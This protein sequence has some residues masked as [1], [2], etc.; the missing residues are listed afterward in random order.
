M[1]E[2]T[3]QAI[4]RKTL[5][6]LNREETPEQMTVAFEALAESNRKALNRIH[7]KINAI[8]TAMGAAGAGIQPLPTITVADA[9][10]AIKNELKD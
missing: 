2:T 8:I 6:V 1:A 4:R 9:I 5:A 10:D 3:R 7:N